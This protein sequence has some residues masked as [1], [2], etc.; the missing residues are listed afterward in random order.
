M[1]STIH[2][3]GNSNALRIPKAILDTAAIREND[4]VELTAVRDTITIQKASRK[5]RSLDELFA[6]YIGERSQE[7]GEAEPL[8]S[9][10]F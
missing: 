9:E 3:W 2:K 5:Y 4:R 1:V 6:G 10:V 8:W 7:H